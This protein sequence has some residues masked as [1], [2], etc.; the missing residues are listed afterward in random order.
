MT[1]TH[2]DGGGH[3]ICTHLGKVPLQHPIVQ[4]IEEE[5][6]AEVH[7]ILWF[8]PTREGAQ[9]TSRAGLSEEEAEEVRSTAPEQHPVSPQLALPRYSDQ[10]RTQSLTHDPL[11][12]E[13]TP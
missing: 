10:F 6:D 12:R 2:P 11:S 4:P 3:V 5:G 13:G 8:D 7:C 1:F 9:M